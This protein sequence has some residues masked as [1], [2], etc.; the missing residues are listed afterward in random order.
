MTEMNKSVVTE[1]KR[2]EARD[3][4]RRKAKERKRNHAVT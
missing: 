4:N 2:V 3:G 1:R